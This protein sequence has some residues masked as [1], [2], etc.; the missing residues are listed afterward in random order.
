MDGIDKNVREDTA[1]ALIDE[2]IKCS[3]DL[4][5]ASPHASQEAFFVKSYDGAS[6]YSRFKDCKFPV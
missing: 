3:Y 6:D 5:Q 2:L 1:V 4:F